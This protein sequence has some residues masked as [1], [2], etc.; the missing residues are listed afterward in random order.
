MAIHQSPVTIQQLSTNHHSTAINHHSM[1]IHQS[2]VTMHT[3]AINQ[4]PF[5]GYQT[6]KAEKERAQTKPNPSKEVTQV[7]GHK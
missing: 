1:A 3:T 7:K 6:L 4:S 5:N 2:P